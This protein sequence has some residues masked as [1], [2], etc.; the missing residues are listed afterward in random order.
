[1]TVAFEFEEKK[2][3]DDNAGKVKVNLL[4]FV[5]SFF[6]FFLVQCYSN[7]L[8]DKVSGWYVSL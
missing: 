1:M 4:I 7:G 6:L 8:W 3:D 5:P 2:E